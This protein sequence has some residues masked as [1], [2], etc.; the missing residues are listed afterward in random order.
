MKKGAAYVGIN[1]EDLRQLPVSAPSLNKQLEIIQSIQAMQEK[2]QK[3]KAI[4][5][6][7]INDLDELKKSILQKA[8]NGE[9]P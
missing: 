9:L 7:K 3:L 8:F 4:Y 1:I 2:T 6:Q 5:Q